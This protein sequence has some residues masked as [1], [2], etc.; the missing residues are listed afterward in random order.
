MSGDSSLWLWFAYPWSLLVNIYFNHQNTVD[1]Y[2]VLCVRKC[3]SLLPGKLLSCP[4]WHATPFPRN[5]PKENSQLNHMHC[6]L[7]F[8]SE[9]ISFSTRFYIHF[10]SFHSKNKLYLW[11]G[12]DLATCICFG[13]VLW[14]AV[15]HTHQYQSLCVRLKTPRGQESVFP[16]IT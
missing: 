11:F 5:Y 13:V 2:S 15:S 7:G 4:F 16:F 6:T 3:S 1:T 10:L 14:F 8:L 9:I 12:C